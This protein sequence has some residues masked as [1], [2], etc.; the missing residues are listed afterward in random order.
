MQ[1]GKPRLT[2]ILYE[3]GHYFVTPEIYGTG[4]FRPQTQ[5][6]AVWRNTSTHAERCAQISGGNGYD[7]AVAECDRRHIS[8]TA[9]NAP[10]S[11]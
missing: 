2:R 8:E 1:A 7:R 10:Y 4:R 5:G 9:A 6:Y 3:R 11:A